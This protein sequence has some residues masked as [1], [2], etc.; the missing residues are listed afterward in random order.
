MGKTNCWA[1]LL[2]IALVCSVLVGPA[3]GQ[4]V[5]GTIYGTVTDPTGARVA[6]ASVLVVNQ[7]T[8]A[9][10]NFVSDSVGSF[11]ATPLP[12]GQ[13]T[14]RATMSGFAEAEIKDLVL[15]VQDRREV[16]LVLQVAGASQQVE[17]TAEAPLLE[18]SVSALGQVIHQENI[19]GLP[20]NGRDFVQLGTLAP[21]A[22]KSEGTQ[23]NNPSAST[24]VRGTTSLTVNG[25]RENDNDWIFDGID[26]NELS[27][28]SISILPSIDA[29]QEFRVLTNNYSAQYGRNGGGTVLI[30]SRSGS[31]SVHGSAFE[32]VRNQIF[33]AR[34]FFDGKT[35]PT[36]RQ[37]QFGGSLGGPVKKDKI[38][39]FGDYQ[40]TRIRKELTFLSTV[41]TGKARQGDFTEP[42]Q[43]QIFDPC[44]GYDVASQTCTSFNTGTRTQFVSGGVP[45][46][47]PANR[48]DPI[49]V[50]LLALYPQPNLS[51]LANNY[52]FN[53]KREVT[54]DQFDI[55]AD[56]VIR[57]S[58]SYFVRFSYDNA[59]QFFPGPL[60]GFGG[61][62]SSF[63]S[64]TIN[65]PRAR[66]VAIVENH[67]FS[68]TTA[69][70]L[71]LG[72]NRV[73]I[74]VVGPSYGQNIAQQ[75]GIPGANLGDQFTSG[76]TRL[77]LAGFNGLGDRLTTPLLLGTNV[78]QYSDNLTHI[79]GGHVLNIGFSLKVDQ[80]NFEGINAPRGNLTFD[81]L[82]TS[83]RS[84]TGFQ[85][86]TGSAVASL[87]L[88]LP[89]QV[90]RSNT[91]GGEPTGDRW[92]D[93]RGY[94]Q[95][96]WKV[97]SGLTLNLG[98]AYQVITPYTEQ[99]S[100]IANLDPATGVM[101][102]AGQ[103]ASA[104]GNV[105]TD[106][107]NLQPRVGFAYTPRAR[108]KFVVRGGYGIF[109]DFVNGGGRGL[110]GNYPF[111]DSPTLVSDSITPQRLLR[112]GFAPPRLTDSKNPSGSIVSQQYDFPM[113]FVQQWNL[114][115]QQ[116]LPWN[117]V[118]TVA[119]VGTH[120][121]R[122]LSKDDINPPAPGAG[123]INPRRPYPSLAAISAILPRG[124]S[125]YNA[126]QTKIEKR[127]SNH[128]YF[129]MGY[130]WSKAIGNEPAESLTFQPNATGQNYFPFAPQGSTSDKGLAAIDL[131]QSFT[132][133]YLYELPFGRG[134][135]LLNGS[136]AAVN[137]LLGGWNV[138]GITRVRTGFPLGA[139]ITPSLLNN[140]MGN[141]PNVVCDPNLPTSQQKVQRFFNTSCFT[142]PASFQFG[143][144]G[145]T[146]GSGPGQV[147]FDFSIL[148]DF[149]IRE[150]M[151]L[152][153]R[154]E[155]FNILNSA[156]F[157]LPSTAIGTGPAGTIAATIN[158]A[159]QIQF[160]L[161]LKF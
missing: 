53:S 156:E 88:G 36:F 3:A 108:G 100:R 132:L 52:L 42:G 82:F 90:M 72:Y 146:F 145:R 128:F 50:K 122:L 20:L 25:M 21:G 103:G 118:I 28:G 134:R 37:N 43:A 114:S 135:K 5:S 68:P 16:N 17:V 76:L 119:Y 149:R 58:D 38:F 153:F 112:D 102:V 93:Y 65:E 59:H 115:V 63:V 92:K 1:G 94:L 13:Y 107:N 49:A 140:T 78:Y 105:T 56:H 40:G 9:Q 15:E 161:K 18:R 120:G 121:G 86:G 106:Y 47:I 147:N 24:S 97:S 31:N 139:T 113:G 143:N 87:L 142:A 83:Q 131:R 144:S 4:V 62:T 129:L 55:R 46:V 123:A 44:S 10:K 32:F 91:I 29:I 148:K 33:D 126:L 117:T 99:H 48:L 154:T 77:N 61:G 136:G 85:S 11:V 30:T 84:G 8:N 110:A 74:T 81:Q 34:N 45:N 98:L 41:P 70:Q 14:V 6:G 19:V 104:T 111:T 157:D 116:E 101:V 51:G 79:R 141:R 69:N 158:D 127:F 27:A 125:T 35:K 155:I 73:F 80:M 138:T 7:A 124:S 12:I 75:L 22:T 2:I 95:D 26:N 96:D 159:R 66:S 109:N 152:E 64:A 150:Q 39:F 71:A 60:P 57:Q 137:Q 23:F 160:G 89:S 54:D 67:V 151:S 130:T 133:S